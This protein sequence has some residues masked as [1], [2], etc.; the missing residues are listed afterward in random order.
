MKVRVTQRDVARLAGVSQATVSLVL[1]GQANA[2][3]RIPI[4]TRERVARVI[5]ETGYVADPIARRLVQKR[6][7]IIGVFSYEPVFPSAQADFFLPFLLGIEQGA[8]Q[9]GYD[10]L[11]FTSAAKGGD[12]RRIFS[13]NN[14]LR[15]ADGC[16][17]LGRELDRAELAQLVSG[18][19][20]FVAIGRRDDAGGPVPYV[21][22]DYATATAALVGQALKFGHRAFGYVGRKPG[23]EASS[24]RWRGFHEAT[25][26]G[27]KALVIDTADPRPVNEALLD[28]RKAGVTAIFYED[29]SDAVQG[30]EAAR[31]MGLY[32]P[33]DLSIVALGN[34]TGSIPTQV[35]FT[36]FNIPRE[37]MG[38]LAVEMLAAS[39]EGHLH[40][41]Q[42]LLPCE[43]VR[44]ET[45]G[46]L[47]ETKRL[48]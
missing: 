36:R 46:F 6:N 43:L 16:I 3:D 24:D 32:L 48:L 37:E 45:L 30:E 28:L 34:P 23:I 14:R 26:S 35:N 1:N 2:I 25:R 18:D 9:F 13:S 17:V 40:E 21:G 47:T 39:L 8:Q 11:L 44:G 31:E 5:R 19:Y 27:E 38:R 20:H 41:R 29:L 7:Q 22:A 15:L 42:R 12:E 33:G 10:V 4:E